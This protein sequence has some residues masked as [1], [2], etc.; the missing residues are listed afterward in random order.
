MGEMAW[1]RNHACPA[2]HPPGPGTHSPRTHL[3]SLLQHQVAMAQ[4]SGES[5]F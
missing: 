5:L 1:R 3:A 4:T 2:R